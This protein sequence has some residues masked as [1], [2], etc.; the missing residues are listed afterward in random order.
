MAVARFFLVGERE[1]DEALRIP[2]RKY[3]SDLSL[4]RYLCSS[5]E[6]SFKFKKKTNDNNR[7]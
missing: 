3:A 1:V 2:L 5:S 7:K 4:G 6:Q